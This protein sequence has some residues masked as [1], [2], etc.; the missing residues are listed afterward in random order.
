MSNR[1]TKEVTRWHKEPYAW[2][3]ILFPALAVIA[4]FVT[5]RLAI[6]SYDGLVTD[7]YYKKGLEINRV[8]ER[9]KRAQALGID[10][11]V[12]FDPF[13]HTF[14]ARMR[15]IDVN[16]LP[17]SLRLK[18]MHST[19]AGFDRDL[20]IERTTDGSYFAILPQL[21]PGRWYAQIETDDWRILK[22]LSVHR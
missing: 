20:T 15:A 10:A 11:D 13:A 22:S 4:S 21:A 12:R 2:L 8:L 16:A 19:R 14:T 1:D 17:P 9:D 5:L 18:L 7:D 3:L 6:N